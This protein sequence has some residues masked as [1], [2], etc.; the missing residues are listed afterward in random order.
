MFKVIYI[1]KKLTEREKRFSTIESECLAIFWSV[2]K[3]RTFFVWKR[4][5]PS[6]RSP[7]SNI[8]QASK[9]SKLSS[10]ALG[11]IFTELPH[12]D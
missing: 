3:L 5:C 12:E 8:P 1:S 6:N 2:K 10:D 4:I 9:I 7:V 11:A